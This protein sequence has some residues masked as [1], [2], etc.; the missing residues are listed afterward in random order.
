M[1]R[2]IMAGLCMA[3]MLSGMGCENGANGMSAANDRSEPT[4]VATASATRAA[5]PAQSAYDRPDFVTQVDEDGRLWVWREGE[6]ME[7]AD[8][9]VTLVAAGPDRRTVKALDR[10]TADAYLAWKPGFTTEFV[11]GRLWVWR[12]GEEQEKPDKHTTMI[13]VGPGG[14]TVKAVERDTIV[15]YLVA[16]EGFATEIDE[17]GRLWVWNEQEAREMPDKH[18][19]MVGAGPMRTTLKGLE[20]ETLEAYL[21]AVGR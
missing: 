7:K 8:K 9:H 19:T 20:R 1:K 4:T 2:M 13:G 17:D 14:V 12:E 6:E 15:A 16:A 3:G 11:E 10:E 5:E 18:V 21:A